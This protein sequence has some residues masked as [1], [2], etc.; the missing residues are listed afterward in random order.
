MRVRGSCWRGLERKVRFLQNELHGIPY[1]KWRKVMPIDAERL[2]IIL[3]YRF[4]KIEFLEQA[5][6]N[7]GYSNEHPC[8]NQSEFR[9]VGDAVLK[10]VLT[11]LLME[12]GHRTGG[13]IT[14]ERVELEKKE[15]LA[16]TARDLGIGSFMILGKG[17]IKEK[18]GES[19]HVLAETLEA[20]AGAMYFDGE[21]DD[22]K[23]VMKKWFEE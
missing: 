20:I 13:A 15:G 1:L 6:T 3:G 4:K 12:K 18:H 22:I 21:F 17:Q 7:K 19:D 23:D 10:L 14:P 9:T 5:L 16:K 11:E 2:E 8:K